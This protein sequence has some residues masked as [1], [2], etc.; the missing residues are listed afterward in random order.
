MY[1][2]NWALIIFGILFFYL[3]Y[4]ISKNSEDIHGLQYDLNDLE[5]QVGVLEGEDWAINSERNKEMQKRKKQ[6]YYDG[7]TSNGEYDA[8]L[9]ID[10]R[11][12]DGKN[13]KLG[14]PVN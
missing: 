12:R 3:I 7:E 6:N 5:V 14:T 13:P 8:S 10:R 9:S 1:I 11:K 4:K 2:Q